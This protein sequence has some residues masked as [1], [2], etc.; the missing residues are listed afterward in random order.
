MIK[1]SGELDDDDGEHGEDY[2]SN[3][4]DPEIAP[5]ISNDNDQDNDPGNISESG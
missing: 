2:D 5:E 1:I 4:V 3:D